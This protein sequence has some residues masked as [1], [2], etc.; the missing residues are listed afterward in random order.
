[1]NFEFGSV[2]SRAHELFRRLETEGAA[3]VETLVA[4][5]KSEELF[6]D[7]KQIATSHDARALHD[8][9]RKNLRKALSGFANSEGGVIL[10]GPKTEKINGVEVLEMP[11]GH[12]D[13]ARFVSLLEDAVSGCTVPPVPGVRSIKIPLSKD[14][15]KGVAATLVPASLI[16]PHQTSDDSRAYHMRAG[17]SFPHVPH[18]VL[19]GM[20]GRRPAPVVSMRL[21]V[22]GCQV[23]GGD[24]R[25]QLILDLDFVIFNAS[26]VLARGAYISWQ[27]NKLASKN[28]KIDVDGP[29]ESQWILN[30][31]DSRNGS[32]IAAEDCRLAPFSRNL[33][34]VLGLNLHLN[35]SDKLAE[36]IEIDIFF[37]CESAPPQRQQLS[38][39]REHIRQAIADLEGQHGSGWRW[40]PKN[41]AIGRRLVGLASQG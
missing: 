19:A 11:D 40:D 2:S 10:W 39:S 20:F 26:S 15:K 24:L 37:G 22:Q 27:A 38:F 33:A 16:A 23:N 4:A 35:S 6:L 21:G 29:F 30:K 13:V 5:Q 36:D 7:Y 25:S 3:F 18:G 32:T 8:S 1:M 12:P 34:L 41:L 9:D 31:V 14:G 17:S 28:S